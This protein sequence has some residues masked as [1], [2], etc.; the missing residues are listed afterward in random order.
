MRV[1][2]PMRR[3]LGLSIIELMISLTL[4]L[5]VLSALVYIYVSSRGTYRG[6]EAVAR[7]QEN[8]RF[9]MDWLSREIRSAGFFGCVSRGLTP[10]IIADGFSGFSMG[11]QA[12]AGAEN[13]S[14]WTSAPSNYLRGD[15]LYLSGMYGTAANVLDTSV[16]ANNNNPVNANVKVDRCIGLNQ[17]DL[18]L[19]TNCARATIMRVTN[20]PEKGSCP[21]TSGSNTVSDANNNNTEDF[22][23]NPPYTV[24]QRAILYK[25]FAFAYFVGTNPAGR[26]ALYRHSAGYTTH[27]GATVNVVNEEVA[28]NI[29]D[30]DLLFG[31]D[32]TG[33]GNV[34]VYRPASEVVSWANV[35]SVRVTLVAVSPDTGATAQAQT[36]Y[37]GAN[38]NGTA[39]GWRTVNDS[40]LR[41]VFT[42]TVA[43][44]NR[45]P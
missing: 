30:M 21:P 25:F 19:A 15:V 3:Q 43:L 31:E 36:Y 1:A 9:A 34:D 38:N 26:P 8:G 40:R 5:V 45:L 4:S 28:E 6:N 10:V 29:E 44:R 11:L 37:F 16:S 35:I 2:A 18:V 7:I 22:R 14:G 17:Y 32:T 27:A 39:V 23:L 20:E 42:S 12:V 41:Q 24:Q 13:G 33:T